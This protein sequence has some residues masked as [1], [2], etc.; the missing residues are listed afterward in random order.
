M[1]AVINVKGYHLGK[2]RKQPSEMFQH[3][4]PAVFP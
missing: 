2:E 3:L 1:T 4:T